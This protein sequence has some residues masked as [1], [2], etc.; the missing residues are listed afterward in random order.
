M[1]GSA[2]FV[3]KL[4]KARSMALPNSMSTRIWDSPMRFEMVRDISQC[5]YRWQLP[6]KNM[7]CMKLFVY[8][9][10]FANMQT[11]Y[12]LNMKQ[13]HWQCIQWGF[14]TARNVF[15]HRSSFLAS[16]KLSKRIIQV[17][18]QLEPNIFFMDAQSQVSVSIGQHFTSCSKFVLWLD[19][20]SISS[21]SELYPPICFFG[22]RLVPSPTS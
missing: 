6:F 22:N 1:C 11:C 17:C 4:I 19:T 15:E 9:N 12:F 20:D 16:A 18:P 8:H 10:C 7:H 14:V 5:R 21:W 13:C 2:D 3:E